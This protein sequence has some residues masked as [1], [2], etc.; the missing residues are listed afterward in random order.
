M[1]LIKRL[2]ETSREL[3]PCLSTAALGLG[4]VTLFKL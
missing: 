1:D 2:P 4:W 3:V